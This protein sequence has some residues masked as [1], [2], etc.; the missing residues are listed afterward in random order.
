MIRRKGDNPVEIIDKKQKKDLTL[1]T[2]LMIKF[3]NNAR[4]KSNKNNCRIIRS[5]QRNA[6]MFKPLFGRW[7]N[8]R[9]EAVE[10][11]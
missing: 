6:K 3:N 10:E 2:L 1:K 4:Y 8:G 11:S 7:R 9:F 5:K